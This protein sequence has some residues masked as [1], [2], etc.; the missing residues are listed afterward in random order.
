MWSLIVINSHAL[1]TAPSKVLVSPVARIWLLTLS[2]IP[3]TGT[4][5]ATADHEH[6][7]PVQGP[8]LRASRDNASLGHIFLGV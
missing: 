8:G 7:S 6:F 5:I 4:D 3:D 1:S 2:G